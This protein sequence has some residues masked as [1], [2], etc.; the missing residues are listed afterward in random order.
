MSLGPSFSLQSGWTRC[1]SRFALLTLLVL[2]E[3]IP[4]S[5]RAS[6]PKRLVLALDGVAYRDMKALQEGVTYKD[7]SG[8]IF[9]RQA[10]HQGYFPVSRMISTFP[11][12]SDVAWTEILGD[13]P[14]P[15]YQRTYFCEAANLEIFHNG[16]TTS[17]EYERQMTWQVTGGL[18][19]TMGYISPRRTF[20]YEV[21]E[22]VKNFL[23]ADNQ[24]DIY[25]A[26]LRSPDDAQHLSADILAML[27]TVDEKLQELRAIYRAREGRELEILIISDHGNNHAGPA[28]RVEI[29][30]FLKQAGYRV[31]KSILN[32]KDVV[33]PTAGIESWVE[34]HNSP[35]ETETLIQLLSHLQGV[36]VLTARDPAHAQRFIVMNSNSERALIEWNTASNSFRYSTQT[37]DPIHYRPVVEALARKNRLDAD[38]FATADAWTAETLAHFYPLAL[39]RIVR[40][41]TRAALNPATILISLDNA[42][43]HSGWFVKHGSDIVRFGGTHGALD[44]LNSNGILLSSFAPTQ[45][46]SANRVAALF[47]GFKGLRDYQAEEMGAEWV[48][49]KAQA[50]TTIARTPLDRVCRTL[51]DDGPLLRIWTPHFARPGNQAPVNVTFSQARQYLPAH[52]R[53]GDPKPVDASEQHLALNCPVSLPGRCSCERLYRLPADL[54]LQPQA[55]YLASG[56]IQDGRSNTRIFRFAFRTDHLGWPIMY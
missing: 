29:R 20:R 18:L 3:A 28:K 35:S 22:L 51:P 33:L 10:F 21:H 31:T 30:K 4:L 41:H 19:R 24:G 32:P 25:Y 42:Y 47:D 5:S 1:V 48:S 54:M 26:L 45:D 49:A 6:L 39:E 9:H 27:C 52:V 14:L 56:R 38:G 11:S 36:D 13:R 17:M 7:L 50:L 53:R 34:V 8:R 2:V 44:S 55:V 46:T 15:G 43:V 23:K 16:I 12:A 37:G 40:G